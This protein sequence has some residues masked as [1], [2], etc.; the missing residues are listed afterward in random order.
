MIIDTCF[1]AEDYRYRILAEDILPLI[2]LYR[3][4]R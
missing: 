4:Y 2:N 1:D 3:Y